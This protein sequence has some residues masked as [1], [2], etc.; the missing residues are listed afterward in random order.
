VDLATDR[1]ID[2][3]DAR[4]QSSGGVERRERHCQQLRGD[5]ARFLRLDADFHHSSMRD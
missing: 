2:R 3:R 5:A 4:G 1:A